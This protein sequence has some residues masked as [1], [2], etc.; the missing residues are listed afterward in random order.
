MHVIG[1]RWI[2]RLGGLMALVGL[3]LLPA[4]SQ[5]ASEED[6]WESFNRPIF[7]FNDT[8]DTY[9]LK[10]I[11]QGYRAVTPQ[12]LE[13]GVHNV[14]GN[15]GDVGNLANNLLQG[16]LHNAGVDTGRL[17]FN[18]TFGVLGFFDVAKH[19][20]LQKSNEDF[21]QTLGVW[22]LNSGPYLVIPLLGPSTVRDATGRVPDSFLT[23]YP[24][25][26]HVPTRNVTRGVQVV[27]TRANLL[28]AERLISGDKYIFIRNA[29]LQ[30]REFKVKDGQ[31][32]DDF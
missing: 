24:H 26:D 30:S 16:K 32:E 6:P 12:F 27:D 18:T 25:M 21:G 15:I 11:A 1:A 23:P 4:M 19:M 9:A 13:D 29:Y 17:I 3:S 28:Q 10:P 20:G 22:G 5:A 14:F 7:R 8:V 31:V 2:A